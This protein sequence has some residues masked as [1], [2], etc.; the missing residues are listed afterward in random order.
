L[1]SILPRNALMSLKPGTTVF[2][3]AGVFLVLLLAWIIVS[4]LSHAAG[5][6]ARDP[7]VI[8]QTRKANKQGRNRLIL[9]FGRAGRVHSLFALVQHVGRKSGR[10]YSTPVRLVRRGDSFII[11]MIYGNRSDWYKNL[12]A[13]GTMKLTWQ[14]QTH[15]VGN[16]EPLE[17]SL[18][19]KEFPWISRFL[20]RL[21]GLPAF[22]RVTIL[23]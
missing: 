6:R 10:E 7:H 2:I 13:A 5:M 4:N 22:L 16:A 18:A 17:V 21:E 3:L 14:G 23:S 9:T 15:R 20:F 19:E 11:P 8:D 1:L 12:L